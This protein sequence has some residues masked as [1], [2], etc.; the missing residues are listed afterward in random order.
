MKPELVP[1]GADTLLLTH[2]VMYEKENYTMLLFKTVNQ[3]LGYGCITSNYEAGLT[4]FS[5]PP[6]LTFELPDQLLP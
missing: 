1:E 3:K 6:F 4:D 5:P 2:S